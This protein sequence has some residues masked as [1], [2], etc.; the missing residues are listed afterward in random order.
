[1]T[2]GL[3]EN[4]EQKIGTTKPGK[5]MSGVF[6]RLVHRPL[7]RELLIVLAFCL[8]TSVLTAPYVGHLR[9]AAA[10]AGDPYLVSWILWW[11]YHA[12]FNHPLSLFHSN[13]FYPLK[14]T[15]AFSEHCYGLAFPFFP[16]FALGFTPLTVHAVALFLGFAL[17]GYGA[18]RLARTL[19]DSYGVAWVAGIIFAFIPFRFHMLSHLP[20]LFSPWIPLLLEAMVLFVRRRSRKRAV[21]L[22]IAFFMTGLTTIS[23][24]TLSLV[25]L[26]LSAAV[27]LTRYSLWRDRQF[28]VR[29][30]TS[31]SVASLALLPFMLPYFSVMK[32]YGFKRSIEEVKANSAW[33]IHWLSV[34]NRNKFW[35]GMGEGIPDGSHFKLFPGLL[36]ILFSLAALPGGSQ[37]PLPEQLLYLSDSTRK[38]LKRLDLL[39]FI[40]VPFALIAIGF[41]GTPYFRGAFR[42]M[43]SECVLTLLTV[44]TIARFC[45]AYP[46]WLPARRANLVE[47][48][49]APNR[50]DAFWLGILLTIIGFCY[51]LGW[52]FFFYR[53]CYDLLPMFRSMRVPI[54]GAMFAY[55]GLALLAGLGVKRLAEVAANLRTR[56]PGAVVVT[57]C[58]GLLLFELN[59]APLQFIR[60]DAYP[61]SVT[62]ALKQISMRGGI[63]TLPAGGDFNYRNTLRSAD[64]GK[65][66]IVGTSGFNSPFEDQI[67]IQT[68]SGNISLAFLDLLESIPASYVV[69][70]NNLITD[71]RQLNYQAL[72]VRGI[73]SGRLRFIRRFDGHNDLYAVTKTEPNAK[74]EQEVPFGLALREWPALVKE[75]PVT[76][77]G[78]Y[79][80]WSQTLFRLN[81]ASFGTM[82]RYADFIRDI[83]ILGRG[84]IPGMEDQDKELQK[85]LNEFAAKWVERIAFEERYARVNDE[86]YVN[87]LIA[88]TGISLSPAERATILSGLSAGTDSRADVLLKVVGLPSFIQKEQNRSLVLLHYF[89]YFRRN[90]DE[91]PDY[92]LNGFNFWIE[93]LERNHNPA[94]LSAAFAESIEYKEFK[95]RR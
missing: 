4:R 94:K 51:S 49:R 93:D 95:S 86:Q 45:L 81:V 61:D 48:L 2:T 62:L 56:V 15:L 89:G 33:P 92:S 88:N 21:W 80:T 65:P 26:A 27:L 30:L 87:L 79:T 19:T 74:S 28:W 73:A 31:V 23:W 7:V 60:G 10:D 12:T 41:D 25:P 18:F 83:Q 13:L 84:V 52:N 70:D 11:D 58:C 5:S 71:D 6:V 57:A 64:H 14:Y 16:L 50:S 77:I 90:P 20:Y 34:E 43:T 32:L 38:W 91:P 54:R 40:S 46:E 67:E 69:V 39:I 9:N 76:M 66:M 42:H 85:N 53:I 82:P 22:G 24:F 47:T 44:A 8:F 75:D 29:G 36:P 37:E 68:R 17:S 72:L 59:A 55:L 78:Q 3:A 35:F 63:V 1:M